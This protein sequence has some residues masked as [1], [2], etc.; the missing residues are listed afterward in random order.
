M[1][2]E[3]ILSTEDYE[4]CNK[5][6]AMRFS[7]MAEALEELLRDPNAD[8]IPFR[9][10]VGRLVDAEWDLRYNKKLNGIVFHTAA[11]RADKPIGKAQAEQLCSA[12]VLGIV[13]TAKLFESN[14]S[15]TCHD[16]VPLFA[17]GNIVAS[18]L[19]NKSDFFMILWLAVLSR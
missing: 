8:L 4:L 3:D 15:C 12:S 2:C 11:L 7:G 16:D 18:Y 13:A 19:S 5:L 1:V 14:L 9:E 17:F 6:K 10:K